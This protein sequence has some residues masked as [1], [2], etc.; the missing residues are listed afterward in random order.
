MANGPLSQRCLWVVWSHWWYLNYREWP[1]VPAS[2]TQHYCSSLLITRVN[3]LPPVCWTRCFKTKWLS[4][5]HFLD[6]WYKHVAVCSLLPLTVLVFMSDFCRNDDLKVEWLVDK[7]LMRLLSDHCTNLWFWL[8]TEHT[9][10]KMF[11]C[12]LALGLW[13][14]IYIFACVNYRHTCGDSRWWSVFQFSLQTR[15]NW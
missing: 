7:V 14:K 9:I 6:L 2:H 10:G 13:N 4:N 5:K 12:T 1:H 3:N 8:L 11:L 15:G